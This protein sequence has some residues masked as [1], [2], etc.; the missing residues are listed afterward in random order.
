MLQGKGGN[1]AILTGKQGLLMVDDDYKVMSD[2]LKKQIQHYGGLDKLTYIINTHWHGD[3]TEGNLSLGNHALIVA[4]DNVRTRLLTTREIKLFKMVS[5]PYPPKALPNMTY[6]KSMKLYMNGEKVQIVHYPT[7]H[8]DGD[9]V[10]FFKQANVVH[11]GDH[12]FSGFF[13]FVDIENGGNVLNMANN[14]KT[15]LALINDQT[16]VIPGHGPLSTKTDL[17]EFYDMLLGTSAEVQKMIDSGMNLK[18]IQEKGLSKRWDSW[19]D[20]FLSTEVWI[21]IVYNS[22]QST[23]N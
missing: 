19:T 21:N 8:T 16:K 1:I 23:A 18:E 14:V 20:G 13:P 12:H 9:S 17:K 11:M 15:V 4:H 2:A 22:L 3:H 5:Q 6:A 7:G 10:I